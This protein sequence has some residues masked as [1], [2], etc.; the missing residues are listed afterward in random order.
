M[1][2]SCV[3]EASATFHTSSNSFKRWKTSS[4]IFFFPSVCRKSE[5]LDFW[6]R[7]KVMLPFWWHHIQTFP[8]DRLSIVVC[9]LPLLNVEPVDGS[10]SSNCLDGSSKKAPVKLHW[11]KFGLLDCCV[12][13]GNLLPQ[14]QILAVAKDFYSFSFSFVK[15]VVNLVSPSAWKKAPSNCIYLANFMHR[16]ASHCCVCAVTFLFVHHIFPIE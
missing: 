11:V 5:L 7:I 3:F 13:L 8:I 9:S 6:R 2:I 1:Q 15:C 16:L 12:E 14:E 4:D 10:S